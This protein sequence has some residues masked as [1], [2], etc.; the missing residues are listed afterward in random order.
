[1][2]S[3]TWT[4]IMPVFPFQPGRRQFV[5]SAVASSLLMPGLL[6]ELLAA[7]DARSAVSRGAAGDAINPVAPKSPHFP[8]K[9]KSV[10]F[11][12][13]SGGV[14]NVDS[15]DPKPQLIADHGKQVVFDHPETRNRP[16]Y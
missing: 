3:C 4:D 16:G 1:M 5:K 14:S 15:F 13:M 12:F 8:P 6:H 9:A 10:I 11:L 2:N 7:D